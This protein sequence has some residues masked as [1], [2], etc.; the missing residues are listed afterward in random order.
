MTAMMIL[1]PTVELGPA[2]I[3]THPVY[4]ARPLLRGRIHQVAAVASVPAGAHL[5]AT[6]GAPA[7]PALLVAAVTWTLMFTTSACYHRL[8]Q[9]LVARF[10]MRRLDHSMIFVHVAGV[11]TA[12]GLV[13]V[14]G[15]L[16][17][18]LVLL[19]WAGA[20]FG[21]VT[22]MTRL[23][24]DGDPCPWLFPALGALPLL[25]APLVASAHGGQAAAWLVA[26]GVMYGIGV[27]CFARRSPDR[28]A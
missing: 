3:A 2:E 24:A 14:G 16:G 28:Y 19:S 23:T 22:K 4:G 21:A 20:G 1:Q 10:W 11:T 6:A 18:S 15:S 8:A 9:G 27:V 13:G 7:R 12:V 26:S 17:R 5:V 25:A